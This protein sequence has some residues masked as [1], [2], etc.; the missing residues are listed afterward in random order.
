[1][2]FNYQIEDRQIPLIIS[3]C[4]PYLLSVR[5]CVIVLVCALHY[6]YC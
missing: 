3:V 2:S 5:L 6:L 1:M 4:Y